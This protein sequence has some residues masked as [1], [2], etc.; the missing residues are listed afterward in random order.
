MFQ[1]EASVASLEREVRAKDKTLMER[2]EQIAVLIATLEG[3]NSGEAL[4]QKVVNLSAE[5]CS[6]KA[7]EGQQAKRLNELA[8]QLRQAQSQQGLKLCEQLRQ[9]KRDLERALSVAQVEAGQLR[10]QVGDMA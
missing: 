5:V 6:L 2:Q 7:V 8:L 9:E 4:R 10:S 3:D 1:K